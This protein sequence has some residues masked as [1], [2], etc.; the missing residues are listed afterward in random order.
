MRKYSDKALRSFFGAREGGQDRPQ[1]INTPQ[2]I[3]DAIL[4]VWPEG[5]ALDPCSN[6]WSSVP[7]K[8]KVFGRYNV[9]L[10][11]YITCH[12][13]SLD[14]PGKTP[15]GHGG[16]LTVFWPDYTYANPPYRK[17]LKWL[18]R[19]VKYKEHMMLVPVRTL[20]VW[21]CN[22]A[23]RAGTIA[24]LKPVVFEG[25]DC[26]YPT[27]LAMFY[28]GNRISLFV[29]A[30]KPLSADIINYQ[31]LLAPEKA[32]DEYIDRMGQMKLQL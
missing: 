26:A 4:Q 2:P 24:E 13:P 27:P 14:L 7:A 21:W 30:F 8:N 19:G 28:F 20:R 32:F 3:I 6:A 10:D 23:Q 29:K 25:Y 18:E 1:D 31:S 5:I 22:C 9:F 12:D 15:K 17:L 16:G 11:D